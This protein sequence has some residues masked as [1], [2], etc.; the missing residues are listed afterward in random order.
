MM[1]EQRFADY[2]LFEKL[3]TTAF[4][5]SFRAGK[6]LGNVIDRH[7]LLQLF[8]GS[9]LEC[10]TFWQ[11]VADRRSLVDSLRDPHLGESIAFDRIDQ[12]PFAAYA[13]SP[14][15]SLEQFFAAVRDQKLPVP[16][17]QALFVIERAALGLTAAHGVTHRGRPVL[18][19]FL[20]PELIH[21]SSD[22]EIKVIGMEAAPGLRN[23][24]SDHPA[25]APYLAPE[26]RNGEAP[27]ASDDVFSL[28]ALLFHLLCGDSLPTDSPDS[29]LQVVDN[30][31]LAA[32]NEPLPT[33]IKNLLKNSFSSRANRIPDAVTWQ[34]VLGKIILDGE[35]NPSTFNLSFMMH[36]VFRSELEAELVKI[37][38]ETALRLTPAEMN[39]CASSG[40]QARVESDT[41]SDLPAIPPEESGTK[42][43]FLTGFMVSFLSAAIF[44]ASYFIFFRTPGE[45]DTGNLVPPPRPIIVSVASEPPFPSTDFSYGIVGLPD[46]EALA[47]S[48]DLILD[49]PEP[50][51]D[52]AETSA[53]DIEVQLQTL[54]AS[55]AEDLET[56]L[57]A[58]YEARLE[59]L[60]R[61]LSTA[62][63]AVAEESP[64]AAPKMARDKPPESLSPPP[65]NAPPAQLAANAADDIKREVKAEEPLGSFEKPASTPALA[66][67]RVASTDPEPTPSL[68]AEEIAAVETT[69]EQVT[70]P[71]IHLPAAVFAPPRLQAP[72]QP[73][74]PAAARRLGKAAT[75]RVRV[76][77]EATG[78]VSVAELTGSPAGFGF[79]A[80]AIAAAKRSRW[81]PAMRNDEPV[82]SWAVLTIEF[83]P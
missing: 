38:H 31:V 45:A 40:D 16:V 10:D 29:L 73:R 65:D 69:S 61:R 76:L 82:E 14:S 28:G 81:T 41:R 74:Y 18:H 42:Q 67:P 54:L 3:S 55:R 52:S 24:L 13:Y 58:E 12:S 6:I 68:G 9:S 64:V 15:R 79:D 26:V 22:G 53:E 83:K 70:E 20:V 5:D 59:E 71:D 36:T 17:E 75:V 43:P 66:Q 63:R 32:G 2:I 39:E 21:L 56:T 49:I 62:D 47:D 44:I 30:G 35:H 23:Q 57:R 80:A 33:V 27:T 19:G 7:V 37:P 48:T 60:E 8:N 72:P 50:P 51:S 34:Q 46:S 4:G 25:F 78:Q 11:L 77:V 1:T